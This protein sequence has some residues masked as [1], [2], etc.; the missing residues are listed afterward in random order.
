MG[1]LDQSLLKLL[2]GISAQIE[3]LREEMRGEISGL[4]GEMQAG[5]AKV[6]EEL[7]EIRAIQDAHGK[8]LSYLTD[9]VDAINRKLSRMG[10]ILRS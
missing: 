2:A 10:E 8:E 7:T 5:F 1:D 9:G 4:R 3:A 6:N